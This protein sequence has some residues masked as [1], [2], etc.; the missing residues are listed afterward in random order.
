MINPKLVTILLLL[1]LASTCVSAIDSV[2]T[3]LARIDITGNRYFT[4]DEIQLIMGIQSGAVVSE[5]KLEQALTDLMNTYQAHGFFFAESNVIAFE[6]D[7]TRDEAN[8]KLEIDEGAAARIGILQLTGIDSSKTEQWRERFE[9]RPGRQFNAQLLQ[10]DIEQAL[11]FAENSGYPFCQIKIQK[12]DISNR[13][14]ENTEIDIILHISPGPRVEL[15]EFLIVGNSITRKQVILRELRLKQGQIYQQRKISAIPRQL[16]RLG[17]FKSADM[18]DL[19]RTDSGGFGLKIKVE[20]GNPNKFDGVIGY[21][22]GTER[23]K[24]YFTGLLNLTLG[25]LLG[26]GRKVDARWQKKDRDS[27]ELGFYYLEPWTLGLPIH[28]GVD[29]RQKIQDTTYIQ[30]DWALEIQLPLTEN[31]TAFSKIGL[32]Q[33]RPD[34]LGSALFSIPRS[35]MQNITLGLVYDATDDPVNPRHGVC[36]Q[37][38]LEYGRKKLE[39]LSTIDQQGSFEQKKVSVDF[40]WFL[41]VFRSQVL[42]ISLHGRQVTSEEAIIPIPEH[43]RLG[44]ARTLR[45]YREEQFRGTR[46]AW[47]NLEYRYILARRSRVF[48]FVDSGYFSRKEKT[49]K[50]VDGIK[51]GYGFGIRLQTTLGILGVDYGL[52]EG[53]GLLGG[54][55]HVGLVNEF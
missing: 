41:P 27:Q 28:C 15:D 43:F 26:T 44:G 35:D 13:T 1:G 19:F 36:Y 42:S 45:G 21:T 31:F 18:P 16:M 50:Q 3:R 10:D 9:T 11:I 17:Y 2:K 25:N 22:P 14:D 40:D 32:R 29:F 51:S 12:I 34:S 8:L 33:V 24:G 55:V 23:Q 52:G 47:I 46:V 49:G 6:I 20:E 37:T 4:E 53:S 48:L 5:E 30:R 54:L 39:L 7:T 38:A